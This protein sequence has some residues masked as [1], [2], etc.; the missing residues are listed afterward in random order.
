MTPEQESRAEVLRAVLTI[1]PRD[2]DNLPAPEDVLAYA[3]WV[4]DGSIS[5][6]TAML[7]QRSI[8]YRNHLE[9]Q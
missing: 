6:M 9:G 3:D 1:A 4:H 5:A 7:G 8:N 2:S